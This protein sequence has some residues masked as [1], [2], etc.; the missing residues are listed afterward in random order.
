MW[1]A[2]SF[3]QVATI[4]PILRVIYNATL[5]LLR[6]RDGFSVS[7]PWNGMEFC[8]LSTNRLY[9]ALILDEFQG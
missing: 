2:E 9:M 8:D 1:Q 3:T 5:T 4:S 7:S 6:S